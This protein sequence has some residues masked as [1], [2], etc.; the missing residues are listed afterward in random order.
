MQE[1]VSGARLLGPNESKHGRLTTFQVVRSFLFMGF[2]FSLNHGCV[3]ALLG[4]ASA[5]LGDELS[6][7]QSG[8]LYVC[9]VLSALTCSGALVSI[10]GSKWSL[11]VGVLLYCA[12][13]S[14]FILSNIE[15]I[16][17]PAAIGGAAIGG[18]AAGNLW[19]AQGVYFGETVKVYCKISN[20]DSREVTSTL[21][22][23][24]AFIYLFFEVAC[25]LLSSL[26]YLTNYGDAFVYVVFTIL[27][28]A[29]TIGMSTVLNMSQYLDE[30]ETGDKGKGFTLEKVMG[31]ANLVINDKKM[32][33]MWP[34]LMSFGALASF[35]NYYVNGTIVKESIGKDYI[36]YL[37]SVVAGSAAICS[38]GFGEVQK[39]YGKGVLLI[40]GQVCFFAEAAFCLMFTNKQLGDYLPLFLLYALHGV[41][42]STFESTMRATFA[43]IWTDDLT[44]YAFAN[45]IIA[46]GGMSSVCFFVFPHISKTAMCIIGM[47]FSAL[48]I[49]GYLATRTLLMHDSRKSVSIN[50]PDIE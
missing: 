21:A 32:L 14:C 1:E 40:L 25:K 31:A 26:L 5:N 38:I 29:A 2:C 4:L 18:F 35:L 46:N 48:G 16:K 39:Q 17:W 11:F 9:Y 13:V 42:R 3:T 10:F 41:G 36:G 47:T 34:A 45:I 30:I 15:A 27:A 12:Y 20:K 22:S 43:D 50:N 19:T 28:V 7:A 23:Y 24:F 8:T 49:I 33:Y 6:G 37:G 44:P